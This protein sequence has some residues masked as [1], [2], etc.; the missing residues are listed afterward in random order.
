MII[1][2]GEIEMINFRRIPLR[3][4]ERSRKFGIDE[5]VHTGGKTGYVLCSLAA[6]DDIYRAAK[7]VYPKDR[8]T[9]TL[10]YLNALNKRKGQGDIHGIMSGLGIVERNAIE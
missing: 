1:F 8:G 5:S 10:Q 3:G 6:G 7:S 2:G 4:V 9:T